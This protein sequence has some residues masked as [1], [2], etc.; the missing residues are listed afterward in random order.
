[1]KIVHS[2]SAT[3]DIEKKLCRRIEKLG[4]INNL[5]CTY[6]QGLSSLNIELKIIIVTQFSITIKMNK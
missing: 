1:M 2:P 3:N 6:N 5:I 4:E